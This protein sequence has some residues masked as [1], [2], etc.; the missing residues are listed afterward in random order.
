VVSL[1]LVPVPGAFAVCR[2]DPD[3]PIPPRVAGARFVAIAR[4]DEELSIVCPEE[5]APTGARI[6]SGWRCLRVQGPLPFYAT[7]IMASLTAPLAAASI[8]IFA[9]STFDTDYLLV[10]QEHLAPAMDALRRAGHEVK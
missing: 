1:V 6:E 3:E 4:T 2:L 7:G 5:L 10:K 8:P 9:I